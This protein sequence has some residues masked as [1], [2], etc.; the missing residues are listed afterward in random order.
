MG[1]RE[2]KHPVY[3]I[4][5][6]FLIVATTVSAFHIQ[7]ANASGT[8][9]ILSDG[10]ISPPGAPITTLNKITYTLTGNV[11]N[12][13]S[14]ERNNILIN[15]AGYAVIGDGSGNGFTLISVNNVTIENTNI[16]NFTYG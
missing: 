7:Q 16:Q 12:S 13:I 11:G 4:L 3:F 9:R 1:R 2:T 10:T 8:I 15:G 5:V 14:V 6:A